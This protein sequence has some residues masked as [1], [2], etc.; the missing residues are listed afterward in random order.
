MEDKSRK[1][2]NRVPP[3]ANDACPMMAPSC[4]W[5]TPGTKSPSGL[6]WSTKVGNTSP[7]A[8]RYA[9]AAVEAAD[10][11]PPPRSR[12]GKYRRR[13][14]RESRGKD[15]ARAASAVRC[16]AASAMRQ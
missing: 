6:L 10:R 14:A 13:P 1:V 15:S 12:A 9:T 5:Y 3:R 11:K 8:L 16:M 7:K 4:E 2:T